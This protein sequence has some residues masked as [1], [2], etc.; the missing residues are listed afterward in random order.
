MRNHDQCRH[1]RPR[2]RQSQSHRHLERLTMVISAPWACSSADIMMDG[3]KVERNYLIVDR[4]LAG[5]HLRSEVGA[6]QIWNRRGRVLEL[7]T[8][9]N[10]TTPRR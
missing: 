6:R 10:A 9:G 4:E 3:K 2:D 5:G 7:W 8:L 1:S